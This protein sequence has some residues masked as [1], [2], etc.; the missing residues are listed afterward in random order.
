MA[1]PVSLLASRRRPGHGPVAPGCVSAAGV[2]AGAMVYRLASRLESRL[3]SLPLS[4][5]VSRRFLAGAPPPKK[6][7]CQRIVFT[8]FGDM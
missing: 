1:A 6:Y 7:S 4:R 3:A 2:P 8:F 5:P